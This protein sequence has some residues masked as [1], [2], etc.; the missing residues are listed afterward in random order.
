MGRPRKDEFDEVSYENRE[1]T[2]HELIQVSIPFWLNAT[3]IDK[4]GNGT[5]TQIVSDFKYTKDEIRKQFQEKEFRIIKFEDFTTKLPNFCERCGRTGTPI[6]QKKSNYDKRHRTRTEHP[7]RS[8][9]SDEYWLNY[10][11]TEKPK[12]CRI[13]KF[14]IEHF[15]FNNPK[16]RISELRKHFFPFYLEKMKKES[17]ISYFFQRLTS[18]SHA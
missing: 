16:N 15:R 1:E 5:G 3:F 12:I 17:D 14:D 9:R 18:V 6:I 13:A 4:Y 10:T 2:K 11:H 7:S 8:N